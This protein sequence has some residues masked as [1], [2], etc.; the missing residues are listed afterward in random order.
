MKIG[1]FK[2][3]RKTYKNSD[4]LLYQCIRVYKYKIN[5]KVLKKG[6]W[7]LLSKKNKK[8]LVFKTYEKKSNSCT[9]L[10]LPSEIRC[11]III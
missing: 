5:T 4:V 10:L 11:A 6:D 2:G 3:K 7:K 1:N 8:L 9:Y